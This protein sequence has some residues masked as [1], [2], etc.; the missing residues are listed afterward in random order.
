MAKK[1]TGNQI[2]RKNV[3][4]TIPELHKNKQAAAKKNLPVDED[5]TLQNSFTYTMYGMLIGAS[6][7]YFAG[8]LTIGFGIGTIIGGL[9]DSYLNT[10]KK[11]KREAI[12]KAQAEKELK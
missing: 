3:T 9:I 10:Q 6:I 12:L 7:G 11:K 8:N 1:N 2:Q 5:P 4:P